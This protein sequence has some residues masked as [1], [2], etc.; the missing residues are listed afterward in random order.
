M[1]LLNAAA[2]GLIL[3]LTT[4][5]AIINAMTFGGG[6]GLVLGFQFSY[7]SGIVVKFIFQSLIPT[8]VILLVNELLEEVIGR[9]VEL[10]LHYR[11]SQ[12]HKRELDLLFIYSLFNMLIAPGFAGI[13]LNNLYDVIVYGFKDFNDLMVKLFRIGEGNL[14]I[15]LL[16]EDAGINFFLGILSMEH[17]QN[18]YFSP[19]MCVLMKEYKLKYQ[20]WM[21]VRSDLMEFGS[22][23]GELLAEI[24]VA[25][26]FQ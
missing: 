22:Y 4:P 16:L 18:N 1:I 6:L 13:A 2:I 21:T 10:E 24:A 3:F 11:F 26:V 7:E 19:R 5:A 8:I 15:S 17:L 9:L 25:F 14:F 23:Y 20:K 12:H